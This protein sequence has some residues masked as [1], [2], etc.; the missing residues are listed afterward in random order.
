MKYIAK[1]AVC[2]VLSFPLISF[3][4]GG[5]EREL[6]YDGSWDYQSGGTDRDL[7][8]DGIWDYQLGSA[9]LDFGKNGSWD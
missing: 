7:V 2:V 8:N 9:E 1:L 4:H 5:T 3:A 6:G